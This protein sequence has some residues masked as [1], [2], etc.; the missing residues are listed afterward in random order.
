MIYPFEAPS[1]FKMPISRVRSVMV[2]YMDRKMTRNPIPTA[3]AIMTVMKAFKA[4]KLLEVIK[5]MYSFTGRTWYLGS[6]WWM[7]SETSSV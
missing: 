2:V 1:D 4:G 5:D 3:M 6:N 7:A